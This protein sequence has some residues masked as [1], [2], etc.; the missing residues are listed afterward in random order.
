MKDV[1]Y[2]LIGGG[3]ASFHAAK[4][5]RRAD[6]EGSVLLVTTEPLPPY[7]LPPLSKEYLRG[8]EDDR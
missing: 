2:L 8:E 5:I 6:P 3:L 4:Q 7:D 1:K